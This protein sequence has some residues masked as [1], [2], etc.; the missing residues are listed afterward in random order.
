LTKAPDAEFVNSLFVDTFR[1]RHDG[2]S[3]QKLQQWKE[4][5]SAS[6]AE[7]EQ[8]AS[9]VDRLVRIAVFRQLDAALIAELFP[10]DFHANLLKLLTKIIAAN[11]P[12]WK[13]S[14][15]ASHIGPPKLIDFDWRVDMKASSDALSRMSVPA[16]LVAMQIQDQPAKQSQV[17]PIRT[18]QF[19]L[20]PEALSTM[21]EGL[22]KIRDQLT[23][24]K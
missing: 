9:A 2:V 14:A 1:Y 10:A 11:M 6:D 7:I 5:L 23:S 15:A 22:T 20:S 24:I 17:P 3:K 12:A 4:K 21:L 18:V 8:L 16:V 19:E 13:E